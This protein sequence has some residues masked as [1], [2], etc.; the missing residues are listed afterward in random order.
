MESTRAT[1][2]RFWR[3]FK[4]NKAGVFGLFVSAMLVFIAVFSPLIAPRDPQDTSAFVEGHSKAPPSLEYL[5]GTDI[6]GYD[7]FSRTVYGARTALLV[8]FGAIAIAAAL[9]ILFGAISGYMG[10]AVDEILMGITNTFLIIPVLPIVLLS[11]KVFYVVLLGTLIASI[12][13]IKLY[14]IILLIGLF[15]WPD[16]A[17]LI[18]AEFM[19][20]KQLEFVEAARCIGAST[21]RTIFT[22]ILPNSLSSFVVVA[23]LKMSWAILIESQLSF[24]GFG[25][26]TTISWGQQLTFGTTVAR[27][28]PWTV[29]FP[30]LALALATIGFN[31]LGDGINDALNPHSREQR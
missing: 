4:K 8:A 17:R 16:M 14:L 27:E 23:T 29:I 18:R 25:D 31:T 2:A 20:T 28:A 6:Q 26:V 9:G 13:N 11:I 22:H 30:G 3:R 19:R 24:L 12:P 7:V 15:G 10:G 21:F 1:F 5:F